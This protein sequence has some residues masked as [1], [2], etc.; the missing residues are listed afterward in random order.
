MSDTRTIT[1]RVNC[2]H[3]GYPLGGCAF[4]RMPR[5]HEQPYIDSHLAEQPGSCPRCAVKRPWMLRLSV[6]EPDADL[7][8]LRLPPSE[9]DAG[10]LPDISRPTAPRALLEWY[11]K[12]TL[13]G[14]HTPRPRSLRCA[15]GHEYKDIA[16]LQDARLDLDH[17]ALDRCADCNVRLQHGQARPPRP[18]SDPTAGQSSPR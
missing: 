10:W 9:G 15:C 17:I 5:E 7:P 12:N 2:G 8:P 1:A 4:E 13:P 18:P 6:A 11:D 14:H 3:C 16:V